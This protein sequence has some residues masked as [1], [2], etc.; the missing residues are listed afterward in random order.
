MA[1]S[2]ILILIAVGLIIYLG[3]ASTGSIT[4]DASY[5][6]SL[7]ELEASLSCPLT[8][9]TV[10]GSGGDTIYIPLRGQSYESYALSRT[11]KKIITTGIN[12]KNGNIEVGEGSCKLGNLAGSSDNYLICDRPYLDRVSAGRE[13]SLIVYFEKESQAGQTQNPVSYDAISQADSQTSQTMT[14]DQGENE[15]PG[16]LSRLWAWFRGLF[17]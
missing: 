14:G 16:I 12:N 13:T 4:L 5:P 11:P 9:K 17:E 7:N 3:L 10:S 2:P 8:S 1:I 6:C 15:T